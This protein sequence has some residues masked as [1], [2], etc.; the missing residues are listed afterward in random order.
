VAG[1]GIS[2]WLKRGR[3]NLRFRTR[4]ALVMFLT[5]G[6][7]SA[8]LM[9]TYLRQEQRIKGYVTGLTS[10]LVAISNVTQTHTQTLLP[11]TANRKQILEA[12]EKAFQNAGFTS[13]TVVDP[14]GEVMAST[15]P[16][17]LG[18]KILI[19][20]RRLAEERPIHIS[21]QFPSVYMDSSATQ[22]TFPIQFPIVQSNKVIGYADLAGV[23]DEVGQALRRIYLVRT[24]WI[25]STLLAGM[26]AIVY[27][28][29]RFTKP[30]DLLVAGAHQVAEGNL[31][32]E[33]PSRGSDEMGRLAQT[34]NQMVERLREHRQLQE[35]LS[36]AEKASLVARFAATVAHEVRNSLNFINLSID[37]IRARQGG[38]E[39]AAS[40]ELARNL[41]NMKDEISRLKRLVSD[42]L[43]IGRQS[44]PQL[45]ECNLKATVEQAVAVVE[46]QAHQQGII[47]KLD[48]A[49]DLPALRADT[50]Q[51]KTCFLNILTNSVQA[52]PNGGEIAVAARTCRRPDGGE[53]IELTFRDTGPGIPAEDRERIFAPYYSTKA[54]GF[55]LGLAITRKIIEDHGGHISAASY[56]GPGALVVVELPLPGLGAS[57]SPELATPTAV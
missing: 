6:A 20:R 49:P 2:G 54:T 33:L 50:G 25:I 23:S 1:N 22:H 51:L 46:K 40:R 52:M 48:F 21:A 9:A 53:R 36:E 43:V 38:G 55:G 44:P 29:F 10:D 42:F 7:T 5:T 31:E 32:V 14:S 24:V 47:F 4:L 39:D 17:R 8:I 28:A 3:F 15:D 56:D 35:R 37:Q 19:K 34:F 18:K 12:Y 11:A 26:F 45:A 30:I 41:T 57:V 27:L 16:H 13:V